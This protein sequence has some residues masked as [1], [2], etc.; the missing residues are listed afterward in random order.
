[1]VQVERG[2][3]HNRSLSKSINSSEQPFRSTVPASAG[4]SET[5]SSP[6]AGAAVALIEEA[7]AARRAMQQLAK[8]ADARGLTMEPDREW[9]YGD[10]WG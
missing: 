5:Y 8:A 4:T 10:G 2:H 1:V 9:T 3:A 7:R 6:V